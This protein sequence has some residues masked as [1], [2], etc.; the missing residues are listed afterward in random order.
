MSH[1]ARGASGGAGSGAGA[2]SGSNP[3][4]HASAPPVTP[5]QLAAAL[6]GHIEEFHSE[7]VDRMLAA[8]DPTAHYCVVLE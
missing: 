3:T 6:V 2:G 4:G 7:D 5:Q 1:V 8:S